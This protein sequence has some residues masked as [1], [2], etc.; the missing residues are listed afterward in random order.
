MVDRRLEEDCVWDPKR[1]KVLGVVK[2]PTEYVNGIRVTPDYKAHE[3]ED[4]WWQE[5]LPGFCEVHKK[6]L[7]GDEEPRNDQVYTMYHGTTLD[8]AE[9][10]IAHGFTPS[11]DGM[12]G[13]GV[14]VSRDEDK[15]ASYPREKKER[16]R[17]V[18]LELR[19]NVGKVKKIDERGHPLQKTWHKHSY[20]TAWVPP[21]CG[22]VP[23]DRE[24]D[25]VWDPNR[26]QVIDVVKSPKNSLRH[27]QNLI[28]EH[29]PGFHKMALTTKKGKIQYIHIM[30]HSNVCPE[31][32]RRSGTRMNGAIMKNPFVWIV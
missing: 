26:I 12:L 1:I 27:L 29:D 7:A 17:Q 4:L 8:A 28:K 25:C 20:D 10:I 13:K 19:V 24:E 2:A 32:L 21:G 14:Y 30:Y 3:L 18:I 11:K 9:Q 23:S 6:Y 31:K 15:A 5:K 22:M 16:H